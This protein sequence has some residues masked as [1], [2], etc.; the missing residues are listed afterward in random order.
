MPEDS[1]IT[2]EIATTPQA[3][4]N[5]VGLWSTVNGNKRDSGGSVSSIDG[6]T[7]ETRAIKEQGYA[8]MMQTWRNRRAV[9]AWRRELGSIQVSKELTDLATDQWR[10]NMRLGYFLAFLEFADALKTKKKARKAAQ[11]K[12]NATPKATPTKMAGK[13]PGGTPGTVAG[14]VKRDARADKVLTRTERLQA[15][16]KVKGE[17]PGAMRNMNGVKV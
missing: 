6:L 4:K 11:A 16:K 3:L 12:E 14:R 8:D 1:T 9:W 2:E 10:L 7:P 13:T 5:L 17:R 15:D